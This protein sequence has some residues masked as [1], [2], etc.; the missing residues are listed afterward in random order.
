MCNLDELKNAS[1]DFIDIN[2]A[3]CIN[4][5]SFLNISFNALCEILDLHLSCAEG[6]DIVN[7]TKKWI[8]ANNPETSKIFE[9]FK[10]INLSSISGA[11]YNSLLVALNSYFI[12]ENLVEFVK[13]QENA[14]NSGTE[15]RACRTIKNVAT[16][17]KGAQVIEGLCYP[18]SL[19]SASEVLLN[20]EI[21]LDEI[22]YYNR[23]SEKPITIQLGR[24]YFLE[25]L[26]SSLYFLGS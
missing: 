19:P 16:I 14:Q 18:D 21:N 10:H 6:I 2:T 22:V 8:A 1:L 9:I 5:E 12:P 15:S 13:E 26:G 23:F 11:E 17:E 4:K 3:E 25:S 24:P 20:G 7:A